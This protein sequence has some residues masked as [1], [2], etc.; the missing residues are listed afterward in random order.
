MGTVSELWIDTKVRSEKVNACRKAIRKIVGKSE[1]EMT[2]WCSSLKRILVE[3]SIRDDGLIQY[4]HPLGKW[5]A[6]KRFARFLNRYVGEGHLTFSGQDGASWGYVFDGC[7]SM[8]EFRR[9]A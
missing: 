7:G 9:E 5:Y 2:P 6:H 1:V 3:V 4:E 8:R